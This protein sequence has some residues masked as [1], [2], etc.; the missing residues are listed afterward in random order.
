MLLERL[1]YVST[2]YGSARALAVAAGLSPGYIG[3]LTTRLRRKPEAGIDGAAAVKI[4]R[5]AGVSLNWLL[6]GEEP[7]DQRVPINLQ[8][9]VREAQQGVYPDVV[10]Q[11]AMMF[12]VARGKDLSRELWRGYLEGLRRELHHVETA[13]ALAASEALNRTPA[14]LKG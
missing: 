8:A 2:R 13:A 10:V 4:A 1:Q 3:T 6:T 9:V 5:T 7:R 11:Q 12:G 14:A